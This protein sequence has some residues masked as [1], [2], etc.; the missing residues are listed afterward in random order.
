[1]VPGFM[2]AKIENETRTGISFKVF[3]TAKQS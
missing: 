1:M 3:V 2:E